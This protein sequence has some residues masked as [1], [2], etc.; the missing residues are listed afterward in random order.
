MN[1]KEII[2]IDE[3]DKYLEH[4]ILGMDNFYENETQYNNIIHNK[5]KW[6]RIQRNN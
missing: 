4:S 6:K 1:K 3:I 2:N 5:R